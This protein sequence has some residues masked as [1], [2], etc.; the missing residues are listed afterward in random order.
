MPL[1]KPFPRWLPLLLLGALSSCTVYNKIFHPYRLPTPAMNPEA[2]AKARAAEKARHRGTSLKPAEVTTDATDPAA[3]GSAP[4]DAA[5]K[6]KTLSYGELPEG[7]KL[8]YDKH[9][10]LKKPKLERRKRHHY[11]TGPLPPRAASRDARRMRKHSRGTGPDSPGRQ[12]S[13]AP[14]TPTPSEGRPPAASPTPTPEPQAAPAPAQKKE[15]K[16]P[17]PKPDPTQPAPGN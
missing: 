17:V 3:P 13:T 2:R 15:K 9:L 11:D 12:A 7:T 14:D 6:K 10:L 5:D 4:G 1:L 16:A 8:K